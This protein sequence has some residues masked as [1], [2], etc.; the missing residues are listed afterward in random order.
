MYLKRVHWVLASASSLRIS[1][2]AAV[3]TQQSLVEWIH[4]L[5]RVPLR[6]GEESRQEK[7]KERKCVPR[8]AV[9]PTSGGRVQ[10]VDPPGDAG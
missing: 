4:W 9:M 5:N 2:F 6:R 10:S 8:G 3:N 7:E 1:V